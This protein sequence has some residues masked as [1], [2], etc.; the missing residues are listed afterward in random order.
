MTISEWAIVFLACAGGALSP[1]P[2][3]AVVMRHASASARAGVVCAWAHASGVA[4][5][6][7]LAVT[8]IAL[9][10]AAHPV[11]RQML[12]LVAGLW[13]IQLARVIWR[14][15]AAV[16]SR[17]QAQGAAARDGFAMAMA[18]PKVMLFFVA[19]FAAAIPQDVSHAGRMLAV[20]TA[21]AVDGLW[22]SL[23]SGFLQIRRLNRYLRQHLSALAIFSAAILML[24][25]LAALLRVVVVLF[26]PIGPDL[27]IVE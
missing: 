23:V 18:N 20:F 16:L 12:W 25:G 2:S 5:Y 10:I 11:L 3:L 14:E 27:T 21:F 13:L 6:A 17:S 15:R 22:Y 1:G 24:F 19:L 7:T 9:L 8:G 26:M 4:V